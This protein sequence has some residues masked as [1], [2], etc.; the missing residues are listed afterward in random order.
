MA[1]ALDSA[2]DGAVCVCA[3]LWAGRANRGYKK[4]LERPR[5]LR[6]K[7]RLGGW[8]GEKMKCRKIEFLSLSL[9]LLPSFLPSSSSSR[10]LSFFEFFTF[11]ELQK[12]CNVC[13]VK[14]RNSSKRDENSRIAAERGSRF[15]VVVGVQGF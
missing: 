5:S 7:L 1:P 14:G 4:M 12:F 2:G 11:Q 15:R 8:F 6:T 10:I 13:I 3:P 9:S